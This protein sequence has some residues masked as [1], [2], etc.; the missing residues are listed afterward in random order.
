MKESLREPLFHVKKNKFVEAPVPLA[1]LADTHG[2]LTAFRKLD[3]SA[4][5]AR[6]A[7][8]GVRLLVVPVDPADDVSDVPEFQAWFSRVRDGAAALLKEAEASEACELLDE[9]HIVAGVHPYG[10]RKLVEDDAVLRRLEALLDDPRCVGV[11]EFGLDV[12]PW[13]ELSLEE[14]VPAFQLQLRMAH[15]RNMPVELHV[16][17][18]E[19]LLATAAHDRA[20]E[21]LREEGMPTAGCDLHCFT[22]GP[23]VMAPFVELGCHVAFGGA[24]TFGRSTDIRAAALACPEH[25]LLSETD[26]PYMAPVPLRGRECEPAMVA[27]TVENLACVREEAAGTPKL[28]TYETLWHN[29]LAFFGLG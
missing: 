25:L 11:G 28:R 4:A 22:S 14:Q 24:S 20:L 21:I 19:G 29:A 1:P 15:E 8:V 26:S 27:F 18:G 9:L 13:S 17:D 3:P 2:H 6:A 7:L 23:E 16:R 5:V 12:G 10:A